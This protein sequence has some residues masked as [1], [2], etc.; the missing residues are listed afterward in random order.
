MSYL[1]ADINPLECKTNFAAA[2][3]RWPH[4]PFKAAILVF[5]KNM[6]AAMFI[7]QEWVHDDFVKDEQARLLDEH[8]ADYFLPTQYELAHNVY[9]LAT[10]ASVV[11]DRIKGFRL[12]AEI[13]GFISKAPVVNNNV[14]NSTKVL[15]MAPPD[16][17]GVKLRQAKL[18]REA[19]E[20]VE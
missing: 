16:P 7:M 5:P 18:L 9:A 1:P 19:A 20:D 6:Q 13:R 4:E 10:G 15:V 11:E 8:G 14:D 12:Y 2:L 3:L 17:E